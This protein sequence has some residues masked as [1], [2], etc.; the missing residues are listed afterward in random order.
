MNRLNAGRTAFALLAAAA[1]TVGCQKVD[2]TIRI[3][4]AQPLSGPLAP[5]GKDM[6]NGVQMAVDEAN[7]AGYA[8][9]GKRVKI[10][11]AVVDDAATPD[12]APVV[13]QQLVD[14]QVVGVIG[15]LNSGCSIPAAPVYAA[16]SIPQFAIS[17]NPKY[18]ELGL[19]TT[20]RLV[21]NDLAQGKAMGSYVIDDLKAQRVAILDDGTLY[22]KGLAAEARKA[23]EARKLKPVFQASVDDKVTKFDEIVKRI[24]ESNVDYMISIINDFQNVELIKQARAAGLAKVQ[25]ISGDTS[26]TDN[27]LK[28]GDDVEGFLATTTVMDAKQL[29]RGAEFEE[30]FAKRYKAGPVYGAAYAY[31]ATKLLLTAI[32]KA[33]S[34]RPADVLEKVRSVDTATAV[35]GAMNFDDRG[36]QT[37]A[38]VGVYRVK[39]KRWNLET[40]SSKW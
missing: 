18:T 26:K 4:V 25:F 30:A 11:L 12:K 32:Q 13:A 8:V 17:T 38:V 20:F 29:I 16:A 14:Q 33:G 36:E 21:A 1:L 6:L 28:G 27:L 35:A 39:G 19:K 24:K 2:D 34:T 5:L 22:G 37:Y 7:A 23:M 9:K 3:G 15:H 10:E 31:D 40:F